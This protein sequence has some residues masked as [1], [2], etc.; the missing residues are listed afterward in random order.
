M[1]FDGLVAAKL[2]QAARDNATI[3]HKTLFIPSL[4]PRIIHPLDAIGRKLVAASFSL[5]RL[6]ALSRRIAL[7]I[8]HQLAVRSQTIV[9]VL[10]PESAVVAVGYRGVPGRLDKHAFPA[11]V[12][13]PVL[14]NVGQSGALPRWLRHLK[15]FY[16]LART[17]S[18]SAR[19]TATR[20]SCTL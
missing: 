12:G 4:L 19:F 9:R 20:A 15:S 3:V 18:S 7:V 2:R 14:T 5:K 8:V 6:V 17:A 11:Q 1:L 16:A 13:A 10:A